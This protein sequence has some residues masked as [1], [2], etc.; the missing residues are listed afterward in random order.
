MPLESK[1]C[2]CLDLGRAYMDYADIDA[3]CLKIFPD[4]PLNAG[5]AFRNAVN[6]DVFDPG[7]NNEGF[8][9]SV[10]WLEPVQDT[11]APSAE[12]VS[13]IK[14]IAEALKKQS[15]EIIFTGSSSMLLAISAGLDFFAPDFSEDTPKLRVIGGEYGNKAFQ[16]IINGVKGKRLA[17]VTAEDGNL[18]PAE[19]LILERLKS[20]ASSAYSFTNNPKSS[21]KNEEAEIFAMKEAFT[22]TEAAMSP[23]A[24]LPLAIGGIN[25]GDILEGAELEP[26][27]D[28]ETFVPSGCAGAGATRELLL[29]LA[30]LNIKNYSASRH[31]FLERGLN[32]EIFVYGDGRLRGLANWLKALFLSAEGIYADAFCLSE[33]PPLRF[34][35]LFETFIQIGATK[36]EPDD[37]DGIINFA[38]MSSMRAMRKSGTPILRIEL[39]EASPYFYGEAISLFQ[40]TAAVMSLWK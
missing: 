28:M 25:I 23:A 33:M 3:L 22:A 7:I 6:G 39:P 20:M 27:P 9:N 17:I 40:K 4:E 10:G 12:D 13:K 19:S 38:L 5:Q 24:L 26:I 8:S 18:S 37:M 29:P 32:R 36:E 15:D 35:R 16:N 14:S 1:K 34:D 21:L 30:S 2:I 31:L 11:L